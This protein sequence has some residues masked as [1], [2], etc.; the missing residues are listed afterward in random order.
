MFSSIVSS[1]CVLIPVYNRQDLLLE[2]LNSLDKSF[3]LNVLVMDDGST[4]LISVNPHMFSPHVVDVFNK[5]YNSG[6]EDTLKIGVEL[7]HKKNFKYFA[8]IDAEDLALGQ[9]FYKQYQLLEQQPDIDWVGGQAIATD[10]NSNEFIYNINV[11]Y[12]AKQIK[13]KFF[14]QSCYLHPAL[15]FRTSA[16]IAAG[17]YRKSFIAAEDM[18]LLLRMGKI[19]KYCGCNLPD[20][21]LNYKINVNGLSS[22]K[23]KIQ[24][25]STLKLQMKYTGWLNIYW[26]LGIIKNLVHLFIPY[27]FLCKIKTKLWGKSIQNID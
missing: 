20:Y 21:V 19:N 15:M 3:P 5:G 27:S 6:I 16:V 25:L 14:M 10:S 24:I 9:R 2:T 8:R 11:P 13:S 4:E 22:Q 12:S 23:R 1:V 7:I 18:D 17:N 26:Y